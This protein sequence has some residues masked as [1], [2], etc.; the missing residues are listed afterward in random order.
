MRNK[1][2]FVF[3]ISVAAFLILSSCSKKTTRVDEQ[4]PPIV[5][6]TPPPVEKEPAKKEPPKE[7]TKPGIELSFKTVYFDFDKYNIRS[8]QREMIA[9]NANVLEAYPN[10]KVL[11][12]GN[13]DERGTIEY[14][15]ALG[16]KRAH[17]V[18]EY[19][20]N[21]G[22]NGDRLST[23]SYGEEEPVDPGHNEVAWAKNR[24][25]EFKI[26]QK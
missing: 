14:N 26:V 9:H 7:E 13:C 19:L 15:L 20:R 16:D 8:N 21:Y 3:I 11:I 17:T 4:P 10:V 23:L 22:I 6:E 25:A 18:K 12:V 1:L 2:F 5:K 24:R